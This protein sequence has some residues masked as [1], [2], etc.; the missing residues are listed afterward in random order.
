MDGG[1]FT[2]RHLQDEKLL[3][4]IAKRRNLY[5]LGINPLIGYLISTSQPKIHIHMSNAK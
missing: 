5:S 4:I 2:K 1:D 3:E